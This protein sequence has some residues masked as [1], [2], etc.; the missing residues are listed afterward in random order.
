MLKHIDL[1][2]IQNKIK[3]I[4]LEPHFLNFI[5]ENHESCIIV[6]HNLDVWIEPIIKKYNLTCFSSVAKV[7]DG[8]LFGIS[9]IL[10][11]GDLVKKFSNRHVI[12]IGD[13]MNDYDMLKNADVSFLYGNTLDPTKKLL[14]IV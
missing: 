14:K 6:T 9:T 8:K 1:K 10:N 13:G 4:D 2:K 7:V 12:A 11:K 3:K 5:K